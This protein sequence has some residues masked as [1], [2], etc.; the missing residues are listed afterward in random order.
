M[1]TERM[2]AS[3]TECGIG[4]LSVQEE[5]VEDKNRARKTHR[6]YKGKRLYFSFWPLWYLPVIR[7]FAATDVLFLID[8]TGSMGGLKYF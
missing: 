3:S 1:E 6:G 2:Y 5:P 8:T 4:E 7:S